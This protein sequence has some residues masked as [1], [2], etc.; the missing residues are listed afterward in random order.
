MKRA[1]TYPWR[2]DST[3]PS[4][5]AV[6]KAENQLTKDAEIMTA[7]LAGI[8]P[9]QIMISTLASF[10]DASFL[11]LQSIFCSSCLETG[12]VSKDDLVDLSSLQKRAQMPA[13][14]NPV[15]TKH[16]HKH[17]GDISII[18]YNDTKHPLSASLHSIVRMAHQT[19]GLILWLG[20]RKSGG[21]DLWIRHYGTHHPR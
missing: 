20:G 10:P 4:K 3:F 8:P 9:S 7:I 2:K 5:A 14:P 21:C 19:S 12:I 16:C 11:E 18:L 17:M 15:T 13:K 6:N 1:D